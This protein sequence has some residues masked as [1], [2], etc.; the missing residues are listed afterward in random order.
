MLFIDFLIFLAGCAGLIISSN[1]VVKSL[2]KVEEYYHLREFIVGFLMIG[3]LTSLPELS[4]GAI[5]ALEQ[6]SALSFGNILG[7][8]VVDITLVMGLVAFIGR[9]VNF[10]AQLEKT[11]LFIISAMTILPVVL[12][13]DGELSR[14]DG[15]IMIGAFV[16]Y[17]IRL[18]FIRKSFKKVQDGK[19][20]KDKVYKNMGIF[21]VSLIILIA[22]ARVIVY[23]A[24]E[25]ANFLS[26]PLV[27]IGLLIVSPGTSLPELSFELGCV[28]K[29]HCSVALGDL[30]GSLAFNSTL[31]LGIVSLIYPVHASF[32]SFIIS[33][34][35]IVS[36][37][38]AFLIFARTGKVMT[39][40]EG[41]VLLIFYVLFVITSILIR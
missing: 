24:S 38:A 21:I 28:L 12:F 34:I 13:L 19:I 39:R 7:A 22:S 35:F 11:T 17:V 32:T 20:S 15:L 29:G 1:F 30:L 4:V 37:L 16:L 18:L 36:S 5:S 9:K 27:L 8:S 26:F 41:S 25:I 40:K 33:S 2:I 6:M 14:I 31:I 23:S 10:E 3:I